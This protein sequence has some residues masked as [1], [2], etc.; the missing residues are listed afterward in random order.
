MRSLSRLP[1]PPRPECGLNDHGI[2]RGYVAL[3]IAREAVL[4][5]R[6]V[7]FWPSGKTTSQS[8]LAEFVGSELLPGSDEMQKWKLLHTQCARCLP[9]DAYRDASRN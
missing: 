7:S 5:T 3:S 4:K 9:M 2:G 6:L 8:S 1:A